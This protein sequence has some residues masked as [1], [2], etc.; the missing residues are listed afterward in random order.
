MKKK[1]GKA[2]VVGAGISGIRTALDLAEVGYRVTLIDRSPHLG[3]I[4]SQLDYQFPTNR[5]GMCKMLPLIDRDSSS[6]YCLRKGLFHENIEILL[7]TELSSVEGEPGHF[8]VGL[9]QR[10]TWIDPDLCIGCGACVEVCPVEV[11]DTFNAGFTSRKAIYLPVPHAIPNPYIIDV[12]ACTRCGACEEACP[13]GAIRLSE[14]ERKK[15]RILVVDDEFIVRD[16]LKAWL[17]D[18]AG[19]SVDTAESGPDALDKLAKQSYQ[20]ML[21]DIK[22]PGMDGV[23]V[24]QKSKEMLPD[25]QV[26][27]MTAYATVETAVEAMKIGALDYL[28]KPF[29]TEMLLPR[30]LQI[31][32]DLESSKGRQI[33]V[34]SLIFCGGTSYFEPTDGKNTLGYK[35]LPGVVTS[36]EFE[37][38]ISGTGPVQGKLIRPNDG[39]PIKKVAWIQCVGSR[40][41][42]TNADFCSNICCMYSIK[43]ALVAKE[44]SDGQIEA[45]IF[46]MDMRTFGKSYQRYR[47]EAEK[48]HGVRFER[49]RVHSIIAADSNGENGDLSLR[50]VDS[51]GTVHE[52]NF[53]MAVLAV[54]QR[55][56]PGT[57]ELSKKLDISLNPWGYCQTEPFSMTR[58]NREGVILGGAYSGLKDI[59][60]SVIQA[61]AAALSAS[62]IIHSTGGSLAPEAIKIPDQTDISREL[63]RIMIAICTCDNAFP[64]F[65]QHQ[66]ALVSR[67]K[68]DPMV[69]AIEFVQRTCTSTGWGALKELVERH[70]PNRILIGAC[71]PYVYA[72]NIKELCQEFGLNQSF[73]DVVD[74]WSSL[75]PLLKTEKEADPKRYMAMV[76]N[77]I[78]AG[79]TKI[80]RVNPSPVPTVRVHQKALVVGGGIAGMT[81]ALAIA[82]HGFEVILIEKEKQLGGNLTWLKR[83]LEGHSVENLLDETVMKIEKHPLIHVYQESEVVASHGDVGHFY[84]SIENKEGIIRSLEHGVVVLATGG[85]EASTSSFNHDKSSAI[86][87]Q[88]KLEQETANN[89]IDAGKIESVVMIQ[90]V[91]SRLEPRNYCSR[92]CCSSALKQALA[93]KEKNPEIA[94]YIFYRDIMS[95]G[96]METYYTKA[97]KAG[98]IFIQYDVDKKPEVV[99]PHDRKI[100]GKV[101]QVHGYDPISGQKVQIDADLV[102]LSTGIVPTLD[103]DLAASF[104]ASVDQDGFFM[105]AETKWRPVDSIREG[106]FACGL[107]HSP[108][109]IEET[110]ATA[111]AAAQKSL[112]ILS[113]E[114]LPSGKVVATV[115]HSL[116]SLCELCIDVCPYGARR[117]DPD[118]EKILVNPVM[119]QGCGSCA[120]VCPNSASILEGFQ[121]EQMFELI[122]TALEGTFVVHPVNEY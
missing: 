119:C 66:K 48:I 57:E 51:S 94:I 33:E 117:L 103:P 74:I 11:A 64:E 42:D 90:C 96:F 30:I 71:L 61:S 88:K 98:I 54:G 15:F 106:V 108:R 31:Y 44:K 55:P 89:S 77:A 100:D 3:G 39:K 56:V 70:K 81:A 75:F 22:M 80:K 110:I 115:R 24:L 62:R 105:E 104:G 23:E 83:T 5:C 26:V 17:D 107:A 86:I 116:C 52:E 38:I 82:D 68:S 95:Y 91:D 114:Y 113:Q 109:S 46:Y 32:E 41:L 93:L 20:L 76:E 67:L 63:P 36:L 25:L 59:S 97:R 111:E 50:Y 53:D 65:L 14:Q 28:I 87:T 1:I 78:L 4:L 34:G 9:R 72:R 85:K 79:L 7:S 69:S 47:D 73:M 122:D 27:M 29:D 120:A 112:R 37:R 16:S 40:D 118:L 92:V 6:Q 18:E 21:L 8:Q 121:E 60:E 2:L 19:F 13:T 10:P 84:T 49:G 101:V 58:T 45:V 43:E 35:N 12:S 99:V 102:V